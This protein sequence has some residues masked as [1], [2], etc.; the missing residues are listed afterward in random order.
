VGSLERNV[1]TSARKFRELRPAH[2]EQIEEV[3]EI[4]LGPR[5]LDGTKWP[6]LEAVKRG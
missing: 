6:V 1:L 2:A 3:N 5:R 4:D